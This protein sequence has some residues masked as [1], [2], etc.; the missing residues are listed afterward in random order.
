MVIP[1]RKHMRVQHHNTLAP[2][3]KAN[4]H[5]TK[6]RNKADKTSRRDVAREQVGERNGKQ[7]KRML[8]HERTRTIDEHRKK[9]TTIACKISDPGA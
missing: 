5:V 8:L 2:Y 1:A 9:K 7:R 6:H 3:T 4:W